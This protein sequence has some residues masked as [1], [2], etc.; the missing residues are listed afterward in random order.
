MLADFRPK[1]EALVGAPLTDHVFAHFFACTP[2]TLTRWTRGARPPK[3]RQRELA[4][5]AALIER[6]LARPSSFEA[7]RVR[8][9][10]DGVTATIE[11][12]KRY[13]RDLDECCGTSLSR[14]EIARLLGVTPWAVADWELGAFVSAEVLGRFRQLLAAARSGK[15][16]LKPVPREK[17]LRQDRPALRVLKSWAP[18]DAETRD[19]PD[20]S[21]RVEAALATR[22]PR[23]L[24]RASAATPERRPPRPRTS[25]RSRCS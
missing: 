24:A 4:A 19:D 13:R 10:L 2:Q 12:V 17:P 25:D 5:L 3:R 23:P 22:D 15:I 11:L 16:P 6:A 21:A 18:D 1:L 7:A 8:E 14:A 9:R 20:S